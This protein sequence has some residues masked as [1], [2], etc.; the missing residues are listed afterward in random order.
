MKHYIINS[1]FPYKGISTFQIRSFLTEERLNIL[2]D[3]L[4]LIKEVYFEDGKN[5]KVNVPFNNNIIKVDIEYIILMIN[6]AKEIS[7]K[8]IEVL[9]KYPILSIEI[10]SNFVDDLLSRGLEFGENS[11]KFLRIC[12]IYRKT[13]I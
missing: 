4:S 10:I 9:E 12:E 13:Y 5:S 11:E 2:K 1:T 3:N 7:E 6:N 8:E